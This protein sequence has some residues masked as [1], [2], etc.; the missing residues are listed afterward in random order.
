VCCVQ[1][2]RIGA[3]D[4][5]RQTT[6]PRRCR[7][8]RARPMLPPTKAPGPLHPRDPRLNANRCSEP[9]ATS[10]RTR[11]YIRAVNLH[12]IRFAAGGTLAKAK[13]AP[14]GRNR[15]GCNRVCKEGTK[16][17]QVN[18]AKA[19]EITVRERLAPI[20]SASLH[21]RYFHT[22]QIAPVEHSTRL[23]A[24]ADKGTRDFVNRHRAQGR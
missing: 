10:D 22:Q 15:D 5:S 9:D 13:A 3:P 12:D 6:T 2:A 1:A 16:C 18:I 4:Q 23:T 17:D 19:R 20:R 21:R 8:Q 7:A 14:E 24:P 11:D